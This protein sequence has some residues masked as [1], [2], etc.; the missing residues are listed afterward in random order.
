VAEQDR[1]CT[2]E[3]QGVLARSLAEAGVDYR[4]ELFKGKKHGFA[5]SDHAGAY[6]AEAGERHWRRLES[7][8]GE[9]L[10]TV[11]ETSAR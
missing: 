7:F 6:D 8:F 5:V 1:G 2:P 3:H 11:E 4:I 9:T 10:D